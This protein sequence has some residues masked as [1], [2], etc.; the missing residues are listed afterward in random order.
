[1]SLIADPS[2]RYGFIGIG[3]MGW[4]MAMNLRQKIPRGSEM[5]IC[6]ISEDR[7]N[8]FI[9]AAHE[10]GAITVAS[11]PREVAERSVSR[12]VASYGGRTLPRQ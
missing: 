3:Q 4:G 9:Q 11:S 5:V 8:N 6:E 1:M 7:R 2:T 12:G 10:K